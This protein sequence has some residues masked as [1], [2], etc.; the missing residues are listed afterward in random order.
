MS[1]KQKRD[2]WVTRRGF[3][4]ASVG[5][6]IGLGNLWRFPFQ[7]YNNGGGAFLFPYLFALL[8]AG[9]PLMIMEYGFG[10]LSRGAAP[11][12][13][14]KLGKKWEWLG[15]WQVMIPVVVMM[16]YSTIVAWSLN[17]LVYSFTQAWGSSPNQ[18]FGVEFLK[19]TD[20]PWNLGG[21]N[22]QIMFSTIIV[23]FANWYI[24]KKG[25]SGGIEKASRIFTP[26]LMVLMIVFMI[27]G[28]TLKGATYGLNYLF[29]PDFE[30][31]LDPQIWISAYGQVFFST[32]IA[33]GVMIA[34]SSYLP[35][36]SDIVN[37][38]F[39]TVLSNSSFDLI[40]GIT[41]FSTL[42]FV[43][44]STGVPFEQVAEGGPGIAFV[45]FPQAISQMPA[46]QIP[47]GILFFLGVFVAGL[48]SSISML[49]S[50]SS[51]ALDKFDISREKMITLIS[52]IGFAGSAL[53]TT[54]AGVHILD[55][56][57]HFVGSYGI[58]LCG[59]IE[60]IILGYVF[61]TKRMRD[62]VNRYSD[63]KIGLWW[64][65]T[66]KYLTPL[67]LG[68]MFINNIIQEFNAPYAG[69][70]KSAIVAFGWVVAIGMPLVAIYF[71]KKSWKNEIQQEL[72]QLPQEVI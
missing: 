69:Y 44:T 3:I 48:S 22:W 68:Y 6:A 45:A 34:Y 32:T 43:A 7:A 49:E 62:H 72:D 51:A 40:A 28:L 42:G 39:I 65:V 15:W 60:A 5:A 11:L 2:Q 57:D 8:T 31:L 59:L 24:T 13:Y 4:F 58:A 46:F 1:K 56:V 70:P 26:M 10:H 54:G 25:I 14:R 20:S 63:F 21:I 41:V 30:A 66:I 27:R 37:N 35:K 36:K 52:I 47:L 38:A 71:S 67:V 23:W 18:F 50:F 29:K 64:D 9:I 16:F 61:G 17:Y 12:S 19:V 53:F 55:I 33:V